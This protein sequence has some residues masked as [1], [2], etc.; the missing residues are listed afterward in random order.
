MD[1]ESL[2]LKAGKW[3]LRGS[4]I[5]FPSGSDKVAQVGVVHFCARGNDLA[6]S[7]EFE[8]MG[9]TDVESTVAASGTASSIFGDFE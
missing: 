6:I 5:F 3:T 2:L 7:Y 1:D 8:N 4:S 9:S